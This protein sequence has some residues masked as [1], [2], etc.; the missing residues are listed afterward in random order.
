MYLG[1]KT[2]MRL[3]VIPFV[4]QAIVM[5]VCIGLSVPHILTSPGCIEASVPV[6]L[7][8]YWCAHHL[9]PRL[10]AKADNVMHDSQHRLDRL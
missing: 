3:M 1:S 10:V 6:T 5:T 7:V 9:S 2:T 8:I 4:I